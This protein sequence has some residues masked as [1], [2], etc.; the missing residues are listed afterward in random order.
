MKNGYHAVPINQVE[1]TCRI[2][3]MLAGHADCQIL[4]EH[5]LPVDSIHLD[6]NGGYQKINRVERSRR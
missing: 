1:P 2:E 3:D 6:G 4:I 5:G